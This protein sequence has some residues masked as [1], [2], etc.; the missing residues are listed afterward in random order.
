MDW[1]EHGNCWKL[2]T[3]KGESDI[4]FEEHNIKEA[5]LYC[6]GCKVADLCL[7]EATRMR[8]VG[9]WG[10]TTAGHRRYLR[11]QLYP[12]NPVQLIVQPR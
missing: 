8:S 7:E 2:D 9:T 5:K 3:G 11:E 12:T 10:G 1:R 4:F 6:K